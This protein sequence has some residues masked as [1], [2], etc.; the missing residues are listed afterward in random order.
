MHKIDGIMKLVLV[1]PE[2]LLKLIITILKPSRKAII[3]KQ[4]IVLIY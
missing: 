4:K 2:I 1:F 3:K